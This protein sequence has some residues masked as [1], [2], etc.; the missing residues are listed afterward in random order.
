M[1]AIVFG[2]IRRRKQREAEETAQQERERELA[3][4]E[5]ELAERETDEEEGGFDDVFVL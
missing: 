2:A 1:G 3:E 4:Q 5:R